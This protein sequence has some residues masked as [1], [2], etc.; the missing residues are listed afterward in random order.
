MARRAK[1]FSITSAPT[2]ASEE[3]HVRALADLI[4]LLIRAEARR[5]ERLDAPRA[6]VP[7]DNGKRPERN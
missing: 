2:E 3:Q 5:L 4:A 1:P 6:L 7:V